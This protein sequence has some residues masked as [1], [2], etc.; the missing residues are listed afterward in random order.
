MAQALVQ[1]LF[2]ISNFGVQMVSQTIFMP[3]INRGCGARYKVGFGSTGA[4]FFALAVAYG[5]ALVLPEGSLLG[6]LS[7]AAVAEATD[8][9]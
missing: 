8:S 3:S 4:I 5:I 7:P 2:E 6:E 9:D 1:E